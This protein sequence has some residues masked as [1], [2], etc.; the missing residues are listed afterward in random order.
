MIHTASPT[1]GGA[2]LLCHVLEDVDELCA[3][4]GLDLR[5]VARDLNVSVCVP[6]TA[7]TAD[8]EEG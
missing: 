7:Q 3:Y 4:T 1:P 5:A 8:F 2:L 6:W